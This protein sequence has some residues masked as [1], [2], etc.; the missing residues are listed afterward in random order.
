MED[1]MVTNLHALYKTDNNLETN[2]IWLALGEGAEFLVRRFG[3]ANGTK[4][5]KLSAIYHK[6]YARLIELGNLPEEKEREIYIN[7]FVESSLLDWKGVKDEKGEDIPFSQEKAKEIF[8]QLPTVF[9]IIVEHASN[10]NNYKEAEDLGN[11]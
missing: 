10:S 6:P 5:K 4:I 3:G 8:A 7:I 1:G 9:D 2:G 11:F